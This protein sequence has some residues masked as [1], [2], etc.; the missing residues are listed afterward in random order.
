MKLQLIRN[1]TLRLEYA[2]RIILIDPLLG[3]KHSY[4][5]Y[6]GIEDNPTVDLPMPA[7]EVLADVD[8][9][10]ISHLHTDHFDKKAQE[11]IDKELPIFCQPGDKEIIETYGFKHVDELE[12]ETQWDQVGIS[13]TGGQHGTGQWA[14]RLNPVSGFVFQHANEPTLYW[15]GDS[16]WCEEV[17]RAL[18]KYQPQVIVTHSAGAELEDSG[19]IVMDAAQ[20]IMVCQAASPAVVIATHMEALD[21]CKTTRKDLQDAVE[22]SG[23]DKNRLLIPNDGE[24]VEID[25]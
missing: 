7:T 23:I 5:S 10:L 1:A 22:K 24:L 6:T 19:P 16:V 20:T 25:N 11:I 18:D 2:G 9:L 14:K 12:S 4:P 3:S 17:E 15:I 8:L 13:R 21:H